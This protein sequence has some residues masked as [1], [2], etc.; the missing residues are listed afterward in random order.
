MDAKKGEAVAPQG[1]DSPKQVKDLSKTEIPVSSLREEKE[2]ELAEKMERLTA[3]KEMIEE[4]KRN[5]SS[6]ESKLTSIA[7][8]KLRF[9]ITEHK[10]EVKSLKSD[11]SKLSREL[12]AKYSDYKNGVSRKSI[13][14]AAKKDSY[15]SK[16]AES[17][18]NALNNYVV[19]MSEKQREYLKTEIEKTSGAKA[20]TVVMRALLKAPRHLHTKVV[21]NANARKGY[22]QHFRTGLGSTKKTPK[23]KNNVTNN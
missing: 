13:R 12:K 6:S 10:V 8:A 20:D 3:I 7:K 2:R 4:K 15:H 1:N 18:K 19:S 16:N 14:I 5:I 17:I 22:F 11:I 23:S 9:E 21:A